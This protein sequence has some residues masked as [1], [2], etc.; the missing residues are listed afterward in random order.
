MSLGTRLASQGSAKDVQAKPQVIL[1]GVEEPERTSSYG[2][3]DSIYT[4]H[5]NNISDCL[6]NV[7]ELNPVEVAS[8]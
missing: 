1:S 3:T 7:G 4:N 6:N 5:T 2:M 8:N